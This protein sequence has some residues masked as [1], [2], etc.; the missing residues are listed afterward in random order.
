MISTSLAVLTHSY[1]VMVAI[2]V[3]LRYVVLRK[4]ETR[5]YSSFVPFFS[6]FINCGFSI[7]V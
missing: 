2:G 6:Y 4:R 5:G 3:M 7:S 1:K